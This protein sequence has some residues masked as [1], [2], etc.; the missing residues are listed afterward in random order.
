LH[1]PDE[2]KI[3]RASLNFEEGKATRDSLRNLLS[4]RKRAFCAAISQH[5]PSHH[6]E[7]SPD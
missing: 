1:V 2:R 3:F 7:S 4:S 5:N 6:S